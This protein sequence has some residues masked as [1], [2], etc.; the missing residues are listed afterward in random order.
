MEQILDN[1]AATMAEEV[2]ITKLVII[3]IFCVLTC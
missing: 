2:V 1:R 3:V